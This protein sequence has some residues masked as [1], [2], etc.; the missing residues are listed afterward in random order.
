MDM[1]GKKVMLGIV[2]VLENKSVKDNSGKYVPIADTRKTNE[3]SKVFNEDGLTTSEIKAGVAEPVFMRTWVDK[4]QGQVID[5]T[6]KDLAPAAG[7]TKPG[8]KAAVAAADDMF[9]D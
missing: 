4:F 1:V 5:K 2:E 8:L 6:S 9:A 7:G 3:I